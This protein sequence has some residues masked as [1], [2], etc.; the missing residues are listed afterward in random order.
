AAD[1]YRVVT[2]REV[3]PKLSS[4]SAVLFGPEDHGLANDELTRCQFH[5]MV[6]TAEFASLNLAQAVLLVAYECHL[7]RIGH[8]VPAPSSKARPATR[9]QLEGF[10]AQL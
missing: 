3:G 7:A 10:F 9:D 6:P 8:R 5:V 2:P 4:S 1:N